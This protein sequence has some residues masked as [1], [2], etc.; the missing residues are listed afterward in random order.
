MFFLSR[1]ARSVLR[2]LF[3]GRAAPA[4]FMLGLIGFGG[5]LYG[6]IRGFETLGQ[7]SA[8]WIILAGAGWL[9]L[10]LAIILGVGPPAWI[11]RIILPDT[12]GFH[13]LT[14]QNALDGEDKTWRDLE[15]ALAGLV[16]P[17]LPEMGGEVRIVLTPFALEVYQSGQR[18]WTNSADMHVEARG[19][20]FDALASLYG[21]LGAIALSNHT[22]TITPTMSAHAHLRALGRRFAAQGKQ[23]P[24]HLGY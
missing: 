11:W 8:T 4:V 6:L 16:W 20:L 21:S 10:A 19:L 1:Y 24:A 15:H 12:C 3:V 17:M 23:L 9:L 18:T 22:L 7:T 13:D 2:S 5:L 14:R